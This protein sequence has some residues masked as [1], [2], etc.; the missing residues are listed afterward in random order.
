MHHNEFGVHEILEAH[1][2]LTDTID[3][4]NQYE[5][6]RP[7]VTDPQL[8]QILDRQVRFM[9]QEYQNMSTYLNQRRGVSPAIY[10]SRSGKQPVQYGLRNPS[11][12]VSPTTGP[13]GWTTVMSPRA[14]WA[15]PN[16][17]LF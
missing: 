17:R 9:H 12:V 8:G 5:L 2:V 7:H 6:Y 14:C 10:Q 13:A 16:H 11:G 1:E 4:I 15:A 3:G